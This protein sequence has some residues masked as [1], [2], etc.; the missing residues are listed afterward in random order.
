MDTDRAVHRVVTSH[1]QLEG[2]GA[3]VY[4]PFRGALAMAQTD[5]FLLLDHLGPVLN[6]PQDNERRSGIRTWASKPSPT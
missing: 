2:G 4:R 3:K 6:G 5:P 1:N